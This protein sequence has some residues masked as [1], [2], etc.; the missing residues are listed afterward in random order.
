[1]KPVFQPTLFALV[2]A[3]AAAL[4]Q[5]AAAQTAVANPTNAADNEARRSLNALF[6]EAWEDSARRFPEWATYRG[7]NRYGDKLTDASEQAL[8]ARDA[9]TRRYLAQAQSIPRAQLSPTERVSLDMFIG[10]Q[11]RFIDQTQFPAWRTMSLGA[12]GGMHTQ[13]ADLLSVSPTGSKERVLQ[14]LARMNAYPQRVDQELVQ[15]RKGLAAG[16]VPPKEVLQRVLSQ[17]DGQ[18]PADVEAGPF[19]APFKRL[20]SSLSAEDRSELQ[21][22]AR[23]AITTHVGPAQ[24][25]LRDFVAG[26]YLPKAP[27]DG[28]LKNYEGG[29]RVYEMLVRQ[30]TT[31]SLGAQAIHDIG[32]R[33]LKR[34]RAEMDG[35]RT[36]TKFDGNWAQFISY[37]NTDPQFFHTSPEALLAGY[38]D[39]AKRLDF[40]MPKLFAELPRAP[41]GVAPMPAHMGSRAEYYSGPALDGTRGGTFF[42]DSLAFRTKPKWQME[43]LVAHETVPGHHLQIARATELRGLPNFRRGGF[44]YTAFSEGWA[45]YAETLG[46]DL[47]LYTDPYQRFGHLQWQAFRAARLVVDTGYHALGWSRQQCIDYMVEQT[48]VNRNFVTGEIDRYTSQPGQALAYMVGK[49]KID[50]LRDRAKA[51]LGARFDIRRF[52]NAVLDQGALPLSTL[53]GVVDEW[54][55][56]Q[57]KAG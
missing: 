48:G 28:A 30:Q 34:L 40:E 47:G 7:D 55:E 2:T 32:L 54:I 43:T 9:L 21:A 57:L 27:P 1:M 39:I 4:C 23:Q 26:E 29:V 10:L 37:L 15:L 18:L 22:A 17:I 25:R 11:Q 52:H 51:K 56:G 49:L 19:Y 13:L 5:P 8:A 36:Q 14:M 35:I 38:R 12:L 6:D 41:Y 42:A 31:T 53:E 3:L 46:G 24:R 33:E 16:W 50:E 20:S 44:G 45:L